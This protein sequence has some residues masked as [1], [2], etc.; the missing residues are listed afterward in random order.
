MHPARRQTGFALHPELMWRP[1]R[2]K[3]GN[4]RV[5]P[6]Q[7]GWR[8]YH[9]QSQLS[10]TDVMAI[11]A[12]PITVGD[13]ARLYGVGQGTIRDIRAGR[14]GRTLTRRQPAIDDGKKPDELAAELVGEIQRITKA[15]RRALRRS[16]ERQ[17]EVAAD[18]KLPPK[19]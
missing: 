1:G 4:F 14:R 3:H 12:S 16:V 15:Y 11:R 7:D 2:P 17:R 13:L 5:V 9:Q 6:K 10:A 8:P 19:C 18:G